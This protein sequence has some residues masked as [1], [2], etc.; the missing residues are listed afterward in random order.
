LLD[1]AKLAIL[2]GSGVAIVL[3]LGY[4]LVISGSRTPRASPSR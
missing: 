4:G 2:V 3:G 1:A